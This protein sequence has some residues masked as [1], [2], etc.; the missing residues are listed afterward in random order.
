MEE[1]IREENTGLD[2]A[3]ITI[4]SLSVIFTFIFLANTWICDDAF[5]TFRVVD[6]MLNGY[7]PVWNVAERVQVYTN[8]LWMFVIT[9]FTFLMREIYYATLLASLITCLAMLITVLMDLRDPLRMFFFFALVISSKAFVDYTSSGLENPLIYFFIAIFFLKYLSD[10][11]ARKELSRGD[12]YF[13]LLVASFAFF[14]RMDTILLFIIPLVHILIRGIRKYRFSMIKVFL[15]GT[16]PASIWLLFATVYYGFPLPNTFYAKVAIG[17]PGSL[18]FKQGLA[19]LANS[20][21]FDPISLLVVALAASLA[22]YVRRA[23][24]ILSAASAVL[25]L[26]YI[27]RVGGDFMAGRFIAAPFLLAAVMLAFVLRDRKAVFA[28][29]ALILVYNF[30]APL[31]PI[32]AGPDYDQA[33]NWRLQNGIHDE[34]GAYHKGTN[35]LFY[36]PFKRIRDR[37]WRVNGKLGVSLRASGK[38][39]F[40]AGDIGWVGYNAGPGVFIIDPMALADPLLARMPASNSFYLE[41]AMGNVRRDIPNGYVESCRKGRNLIVDRKLHDYYDGLL[42][43]IRGPI[44]SW[45]R[46]GDI[47]RYNV[48]DRRQIAYMPPNRR[49]VIV[50]ARASHHRFQTHVGERRPVTG[51]IASRGTEG[52]L[53]TGPYIPLQPG[54]YAVEWRGSVE[55]KPEGPLGFV[56]VCYRNGLE[57]IARSE[58]GR[59]KPGSAKGVLAR[60]EFGIDRYIEDLEYRFYVRDGARVTLSRIT[61]LRRK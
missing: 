56:D 34:R 13:F 49:G 26:L 45:Q 47:I 52:F 32:K 19:Y 58:I 22:L 17:M 44:F 5:I 30:F 36:D 33:W 55:E 50:S 12:I 25:Y 3:G 48:G 41:F 6:N 29:L 20:I 28:A 31:A 57:V 4:I 59:I 42:R 16:L 24:L 11:E 43:I 18:V 37:D 14:N 35:I 38:K 54:N 23:Y 53:Q 8:P 39:V 51:E 7:G 61:L 27:V 46:F 60:I 9:I 2:I 10:F 40:V 15:L 21:N 1:L